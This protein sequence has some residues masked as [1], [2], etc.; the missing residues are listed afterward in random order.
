MGEID[1]NDEKMVRINVNI[2]GPSPPQ[3]LTLPSSIKVN[4]LSFLLLLLLIKYFICGD[5]IAVVL[6]VYNESLCFGSL[7]VA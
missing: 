7:L 6:F 2:I 3:R 5:R 4:P 1:E